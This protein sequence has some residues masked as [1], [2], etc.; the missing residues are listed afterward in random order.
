MKTLSFNVVHQSEREQHASN[1]VY[2]NDKLPPDEL[3]R[4]MQ[5]A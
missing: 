1:I 5:S 2:Q 3:E 4:E